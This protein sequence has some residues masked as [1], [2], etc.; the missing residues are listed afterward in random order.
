MR[1]FILS[2]LQRFQSV[3]PH[4]AAVH[5]Q[6]MQP[7][8]PQV[9]TKARKQNKKSEL[10]LPGKPAQKQWKLSPYC[11]LC[12]QRGRTLCC[13]L[14]SVDPSHAPLG[15]AGLCKCLQITI[16]L[17]HPFGTSRHV[18]L[19]SGKV[20][21]RATLI[22]FKCVWIIF[23]WNGV[24]FDV[25]LMAKMHLGLGL[26]HSFVSRFARCFRLVCPHVSVW[27]PHESAE[28][29]THEVRWNSGAH[30]LH[31]DF[32]SRRKTKKSL[33]FLQSWEAKTR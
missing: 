32:H 27:E 33:L 21:Q 5:A 7:I 23:V 3:R 14:V 29:L 9:M 26:C 11:Q 15:N 1:F 20:K 12:L 17:S 24:C 4:D 22:L 31:S 28:L 10:L 18:R 25:C 2:C 30:Q 16:F 19:E 6:E 13:T 8:C